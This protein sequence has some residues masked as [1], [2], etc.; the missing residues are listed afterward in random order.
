MLTVCC[1][2][3]G[4]KYGPEYVEI[5]RDMVKRNLGM[6]HRFVCLTDDPDGVSCETMPLPGN[7]HGWWNKLYL[8]KP[9]LFEGRILFLDLDVCIV[10][11]IEKI[12]KPGIIKDWNL[13]GY[14]SSVM[15]WDAGDHAEAWE[16]FN[17][18]VAQRLHGDQDFLNE[19]G[20]WEVYEDGLCVSYRKH[21][22]DWPPE[23]ASVVCFHGEPKPAS[24][25]STWVSDI[26]K[27]G[28]LARPRFISGLNT[29]PDVMAK[30]IEFNLSR[31]DI[32]VF[33][34]QE[35][36]TGK[37]LIVGGGPSLV[38]VLPKIRQMKTRG[39]VIF[40]LNGTHDWLIERGLVPD[41]HVMLDARQKNVEF[42]KTP[43]KKVTYL[44]AS[45]CH[46]DVFDALEGYHVVQWVGWTHDAE[47]I[48]DRHPDIPLT[49]VGGGNTVGLKAMCIAHLWGFRKHSPIRVRFI[50]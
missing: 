7:L 6:Q 3:W 14:N 45:Q 23:S 15:C 12:V 35:A 44:I 32:E 5:L 25:P 30:Q 9:G 29:S 13:H 27:I 19:L 48:A 34:G 11:P 4:K 17:P 26:W 41:F 24:F 38:E 50:L 28:G 21:A 43:N 42:I 31:K 46:P 8:F 33:I 36:H 22:Q 37:A 2:K 20:G 1:V 49:I 16:K 10:G 39:A 40:A 18:D 47:E